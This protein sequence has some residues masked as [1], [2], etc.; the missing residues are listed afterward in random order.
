MD[1]VTYLLAS[2]YVSTLLDLTESTFAKW[3][4]CDRE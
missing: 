3:F 1:G 4:A 2:E